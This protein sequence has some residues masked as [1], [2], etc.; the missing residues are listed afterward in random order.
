MKIIEEKKKILEDEII[1]EEDARVK[2][3]HSSMRGM[4]LFFFLKV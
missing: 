2:D 4:P 3:H 1:E